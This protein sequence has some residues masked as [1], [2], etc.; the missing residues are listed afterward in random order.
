MEIYILVNEQHT[1][2]FSEEELQEK[3]A[4]G[5]ITGED[6]VWTE[7]MDGWTPLRD[8]LQTEETGGDAGSAEDAYT[9]SVYY[10]INSLKVTYGEYAEMAGGLG[11]LIA[12]GCKLFRI[13][14]SLG[15]GLPEVPPPEWM[16]AREDELPEGASACFTAALPEWEQQGFR[17]AHY[18]MFR[19]S[20]LPVNVVTMNMVHVG[21][22]MLGRVFFA[23]QPTGDQVILLTLTVLSDG[24]LVQTAVSKKPPGIKP[25]P[26]HLTLR[27]TSG[28][29]ET[30]VK[31]HG[32]HVGKHSRKQPVQA[33]PDADSVLRTLHAL[34]TRSM[35][36]QVS[37][38]VYQRMSQ[39]EVQALRNQP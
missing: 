18:T 1:G 29:V 15:R 26:E 34:E 10:K 2:P 22:E 24:R 37:R 7:G 20:Y 16:V 23:R 30:L 17:F 5:E 35:E 3:F 11:L 14:L 28:N 31:R 39:E 27:L 38:G 9:P 13:P 32:L 8:F 19:K 6:Y 12:W 21:G 36:Y 4:A 33:L 25:P